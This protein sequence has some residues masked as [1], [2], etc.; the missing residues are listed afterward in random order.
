MGEL[1][2]GVRRNKEPITA[3]WMNEAI[4]RDKL[5]AQ[6]GYVPPVHVRH[7]GKGVKTE[8]VGHFRLTRVGKH[9]H[10]GK[11]I[12]AL[13]A[14]ITGVP[15]SQYDRI[16]NGE[17]PY[18]SVEIHDFDTPEVQSLALLDD[19]VPFFRFPNLQIDRQEPVGG[20]E[21]PA[22]QF[23]DATQP[24]IGFIA[25]GDGATALFRFREESEM[26]EQITTLT[27]Q[28]ESLQAEI[29]KLQAQVAVD[30]NE[31]QTD[32]EMIAQNA[33]AEPTEVDL[34]AQDGEI[35][36]LKAELHA[37]RDKDAERDRKE[38]S[39][40]AFSAAID[41]LAGYSISDETRAHFAALAEKDADMLNNA[42]QVYKSTARRDP[43]SSLDDAFDTESDTPEVAKFAAHGPDA[44]EKART[45]SKQYASLKS[46]GMKAS[47]ETFLA[48]NVGGALTSQEA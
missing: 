7:H 45:L 42:V 44:L 14:D 10:E 36:T 41:S 1:P 2:A 32:E 6:E 20:I 22:T 23:S 35:A 39:A 30:K 11:D 31:P 24:A 25:N 37:L 26:D 13:F 9:R 29:T 12:D 46:L 43:P 19:E 17:M 28:V 3:S 38:A 33:P 8:R 40:T 16:R 21:A 15:Q 48:T 18:R 4:V 5:R 27:A 47:L 34:S